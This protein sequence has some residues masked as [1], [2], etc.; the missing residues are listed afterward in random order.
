VERDIIIGDYLNVAWSGRCL[1]LAMTVLGM[2]MSGSSW[3]FDGDPLGL[4]VRR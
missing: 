3:N 1:I 2:R 4:M